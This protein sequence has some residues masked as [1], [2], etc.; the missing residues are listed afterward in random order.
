MLTQLVYASSV[1]HALSEGDIDDI[2]QTSRRNNAEADVTGA[3]FHSRGNFMQVLEGP[4]T[5][6][7]EVYRRIE[8]DPR[9]R[10]HAVLLR[11]PVGRR[12]FPDTPMA[13]FAFDPSS[14]EEREVTRRLFDQSTPDR[15]RAHLLLRTL[16]EWDRAE[17][18]PR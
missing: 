9:H 7:A 5:S 11:D 2:L 1:T 16:L 6:V 12:S 17:E 18:T 15:T 4:T 13:Y 8:T 10:G 3:L 14:D